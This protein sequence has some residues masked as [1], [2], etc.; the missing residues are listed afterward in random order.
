[1]DS[2]AACY[3]RR[4]NEGDPAAPEDHEAWLDPKNQHVRELSEKAYPAGRLTL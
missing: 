4:F 3:T 1:M 2:R